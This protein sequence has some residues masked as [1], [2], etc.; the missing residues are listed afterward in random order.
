MY[1][2]MCYTCVYMLY[3]YTHVIYIYIYMYTN[4]FIIV[5]TM[6]AQQLRART[7]LLGKPTF[8]THARPWYQQGVWPCCSLPCN[9][10]C[11]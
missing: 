2:H 9:T 10:Y 4:I 11:T 7:D 8:A 1:I 6:H 5:T 3:V